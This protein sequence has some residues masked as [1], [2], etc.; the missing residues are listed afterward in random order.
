LRSDRLVVRWTTATAT[1]R[2]PGGDVWVLSLDQAGA[3]F[4]P[5]V[6]TAA[7]EGYG[8]LSPDGH[9]LAYVSN[10]SALCQVYLQAF[11]GPC[12]RRQVSANGGLEPQWSRDGKELFYLA[13]GQTLMAVSVQSTSSTVELS[14][15][16]ALFTTRVNS[17]EAQA[18]ARHYA[19][20]RDA[21][22][23]L[24]S[25]SARP[26]AEAISVVLNLP[27]TLRR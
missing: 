12:L 15:P 1:S 3:A 16:G 6:T 27:A 26:Q 8:T 11:P 14:P 2:A 7:D 18:V 17:T 21:T 24:I 23:F 5:V 19:V 13:P 20:S 25:R 9:W 10:E 22:K 4:V